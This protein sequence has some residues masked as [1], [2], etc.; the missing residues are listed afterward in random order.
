MSSSPR[1]P[2]EYFCPASQYVRRNIPVP[3]P[4]DMVRTISVLLL[5]MS[6]AIVL[7]TTPMIW[8]G[9]CVLPSPRYPEGISREKER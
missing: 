4:H 2:E 9:I 8:G 6:V 5:N 3:L 1:C 7:S